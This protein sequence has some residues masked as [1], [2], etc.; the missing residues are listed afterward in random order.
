M[1]KFTNLML[2]VA[3]TVMIVVGVAAQ[4]GTVSVGGLGGGRHGS[5]DGAT[6]HPPASTASRPSPSPEASSSPTG[7]PQPAPAAAQPVV[8]SG[9][10]E[11]DGGHNGGGGHGHG[12]GHGG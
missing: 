8:W 6:T 12:H 1:G 7:N 5:V 4:T 2:V 11:G 9:G 10:D 3:A